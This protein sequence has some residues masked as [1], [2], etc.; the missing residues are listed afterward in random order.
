MEKQ[1]AQLYKPLFLYVRKRINNLEDAEDITQD[2]FYKLS[3]SN[4]ETIDN[5][6]SWIYSI[7]KNTITDFYRKKKLKTNDIEEFVF[8]EE[9]DD[10]ESVLELSKCMRIFIE[11]LPEDYKELMRLS[12][13]ENY[14]QKEIAEMLGMNYIT[15][16]SKIQRGR[17]KLKSIVTDCC[18]VHQ[19]GKG[20]I[21]DFEENNG[22]SP[23]SKKC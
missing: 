11:K 7:A 16:R 5:V 6:K 8:E 20:S 4:I 1:I 22:C 19:G 10:T 21:V 3:K 9:F 17:K 15:V 23:T 2:V 18:T 12:E 13:I 14:A